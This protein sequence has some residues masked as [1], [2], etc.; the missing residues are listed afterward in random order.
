ML[1]PVPAQPFHTK[2]RLAGVLAAA[3]L[4]VTT[5]GCVKQVFVGAEQA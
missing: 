5:A 4:V 2:S 3:D 1:T